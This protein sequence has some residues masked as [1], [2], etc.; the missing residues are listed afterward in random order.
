M[1]ILKPPLC[2]MSDPVIVLE[3]LSPFTDWS[4][5]RFLP[6]GSFVNHATQTYQ[7][8]SV[9]T[10]LPLLPSGIIAEDSSA[11]KAWGGG[12]LGRR[13][14]W[15]EK[16][17]ISNT[18]NNIVIIFKDTFIILEGFE[19]WVRRRGRHGRHFMTM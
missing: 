12:R 8:C 13:G 3:I 2:L 14:Q 16:G 11:V 19:N 5:E 9:G 15:E 17:Y 18:F 7:V 10:F 6:A 1:A 4:S